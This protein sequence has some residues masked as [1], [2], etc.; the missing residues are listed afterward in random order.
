[1]SKEMGVGCTGS[2]MRYEMKFVFDVEMEGSRFG[3]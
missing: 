1:M 2:E 3:R